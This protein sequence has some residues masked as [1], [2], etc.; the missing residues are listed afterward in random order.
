VASWL[1]WTALRSVTSHRRMKAASLVVMSVSGGLLVRNAT[2]ALVFV[3]VA[4]FGATIEWPVLPALGIA[5]AGWVSMF[6]SI[7][8]SGGHRYGD[9]IG[10]LAATFGAMVT[11]SS[12]RQAVQMAEQVAQVRLQKERAEVEAARAQV[13][14]ERNHLARELHDVLAHTL[15]ALSVQLEAFDTVVDC[16]PNASPAVREQLEKSKTLV[17]EGLNEAR[18]A[19]RVLR[20]NSLPMDE[21]LKRLCHEHNATLSIAGDVRDLSPQ[22]T[23]NLFRVTQ[24]ALTNVVK[25]APGAPTT[26]SL[27]FEP[28][29]VTLVVENGP[30]ASAVS[31]PLDNAGGGYGLQG[32]KERLEL[33][34]GRVETGP[35]D[36]G[37]RI[38]AEVPTQT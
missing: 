26:V 19:V 30:S 29:S 17:H 13:L 20:E 32:I 33:I 24:E 6:V 28:A 37:W 35:N 9:A 31:K 38:A 11:G 1:C 34:G 15:A 10:G 4:S 36:G 21:Q 27:S 5:A 7:A 22:I 16:D 3:A 2:V 8:A 12:R 14:A 18:G 25:H 23:L